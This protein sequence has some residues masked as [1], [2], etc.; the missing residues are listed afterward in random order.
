[1]N[2]CVEATDLADGVCLLPK[3]RDGCFGMSVW[4]FAALERWVWFGS[5][6]GGRMRGDGE[7]WSLRCFPLKGGA[8]RQLECQTGAA[9]PG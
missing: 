6:S 9:T 3:E 2:V 8:A 4:A 1:M 7:A 5:V